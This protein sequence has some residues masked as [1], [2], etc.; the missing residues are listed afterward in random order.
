MA[1][2]RQTRVQYDRIAAQYDTQPYRQKEVDAHLVAFLRGRPSDASAAAILD[3]GCGTGSQ[4]VANRPHLPE[5]PMVGLDLSHGMLAQARQKAPDILWVQADS[6]Q[7]PFPDG[8]F[9]YIT[10][11]FAFHHVRDQEAMATAVF[12]L[13]RSGGRFVLTNIAPQEMRGWV[14]YRYFPA[15]LDLDLRDFPARD[16]LLALLHQAGLTRITCDLH[17]MSAAQDLRQF[18]ETVQRRDTCSQLLVIADPDYEAGVRQITHDLQ[19]GCREV[20][21]EFCLLTLCATKP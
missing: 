11:Q 10:N 6:S 21:T 1:T 4:L 2:S 7:P 18:L 9:D 20:P 19:Q 5:A 13:L 12:R 8:S 17:R 16:S 3:L 14:Y 15:A